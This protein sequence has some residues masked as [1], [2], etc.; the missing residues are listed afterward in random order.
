MVRLRP[1]NPIHRPGR[2]RAPRLFEY[3]IRTQLLR[4]RYARH[5]RPVLRR[6]VAYLAGRRSGRRRCSH[7]CAR[8]HR[9]HHVQR[10][11]R[12]DLVIGEW[13]SGE[14]DPPGDHCSNAPTAARISATPTARRRSAASQWQVGRHLRQRFRQLERRRGHLRHVRG[15]G[16]GCH[17]V[18]LS[19]HR[20]RQAATAS[21]TWRP[22]TSMAI[23]SPTMCMRAT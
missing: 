16:F 8:Y 22:P 5:G 14:C 13:T 17:R 6:R 18:L 1:S 7:L 3:A 11:Q 10:D 2:M 19:Q 20:R 4:R 12:G 23:T 9:S 21:R 15:A